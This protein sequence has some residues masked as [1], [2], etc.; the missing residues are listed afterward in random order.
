MVCHNPSSDSL[1]RAEIVFIGDMRCRVVRARAVSG[2]VL[3]TVDEVTNRD[4]AGELKG[5]K[6]F[7]DRDSLQLDADDVLLTDLVGCAVELEDGTAWGTIA[8]IE[9]GAQNRLVIHDGN[10]ERLIPIV[11][12]LIIEVD[13]EGQRVVVAPA[14]EWPESRRK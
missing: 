11:D 13:I 4:R 2:A 1:T 5:T 10:I 14:E 6:V 9:T 7:V 12:E 8:A 3:L